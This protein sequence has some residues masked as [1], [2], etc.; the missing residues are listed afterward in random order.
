MV[1]RTIT[2][3]AVL[4]VAV[5]HVVSV[6]V[7]CSIACVSIDGWKVVGQKEVMFVEFVITYYDIILE[8]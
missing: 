4:Q 7:D 3:T 8:T 6:C 5:L 1:Y 2:V